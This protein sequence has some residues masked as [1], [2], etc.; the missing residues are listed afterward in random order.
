MKDRE[1]ARGAELE[2]IAAGL[3]L[4][5]A[6]AAGRLPKLSGVGIV[7]DV[8]I[9]RSFERN[10]EGQVSADWICDIGAVQRV[11]VLSGGLA[12]NVASPA[13]SPQNARC[14]GKAP[15]EV[16]ALKGQVSRVSRWE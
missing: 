3:R 2:L 15:L 12:F 1:D 5:I 9:G 4:E 7:L 11:R 16:F 14:S 10:I 8:N 6:R 13:D